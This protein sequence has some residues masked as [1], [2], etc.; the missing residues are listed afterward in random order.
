MR[1]KYYIPPSDEIFNKLVKAVKKVWKKYEK[2]SPEYYKGKME[3]VDYLNKNIADN[4]MMLV[5]MFD[6]ANMFELTSYI[7]DDVSNAIA[8]RLGKDNL[9]F[10]LFNRK[11]Y[12][13]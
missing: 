4:F 5:S 10:P 9:Y 2:D 11:G 7:D 1:N 3:I 13:D 12:D 8:E 6:N